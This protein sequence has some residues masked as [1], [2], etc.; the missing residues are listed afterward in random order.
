MRIMRAGLAMAVVGLLN[1]ALIV[2]A[3]DTSPSPTPT[4]N[5]V[6]EL[7]KTQEEIAAKEAEIANI[8]NEIKELS[9][10][11]DQTASEAAIIA[12]RVR[13][14]EQQLEKAQLELKQTR[15][16]ITKVQSEAASTEEQVEVLQDNIHSGR[17][18]LRS[19]VRALYQQ[20]S[21]SFIRMFFDSR[22][23]SEVLTVRAVY[24]E[25]QQRT[26][27]VIQEMRQQEEELNK[28]SEA[29]EQQEQDLGQLA[30]LLAA[31]QAEVADKEAEQAEFLVAKKEE[32]AVY[33][34][35]IKEAQEARKE[36]EQHVFT[37]KDAGVEVTL[38]N[39]FDMARHASK[40]TGVPASLLLGVL[41][42]ESNLGNNIGSGVYPDD[43]HPGSREA[44][45][46]I[47]DRLGLDRNTAQIS[48]R[49]RSMKGW[50]GAM[51]PA[52]IM[53]ATWESI[54]PRLEQLMGKKPV[55]PY[56]LTDAFVATAIFLADRGAAR[57]ETI[58]EAVGRYIA[59]PNWQYYDWYIDRVLAVAGEYA[60]EGL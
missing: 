5:A 12:G 33:E 37:L 9:G 36:I 8:D 45:V 25:L 22:S 43:M 39:A 58:R 24:E 55:N 60:K 48:A 59:G 52:Q 31:Q 13:Q 14:L 53:P 34:R 10:K 7:A 1:G 23:L 28:Q 3:Q 57:P 4:P 30:N 21:D 38:D 41:K 32:Q 11:R 50:G 47:T 26:M 54:E 17:E 49:P 2:H 56:E 35:K 27:T 16:H 51:G 18:Q 46:R 29:L 40:L 15:L 42:V 6:T 44:F 20:E 19:L